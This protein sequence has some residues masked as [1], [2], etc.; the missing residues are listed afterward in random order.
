MFISYRPVAAL[1]AALTTS[2]LFIFVD[3]LLRYAG[4]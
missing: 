3:F 1:L 2:V 4:Q